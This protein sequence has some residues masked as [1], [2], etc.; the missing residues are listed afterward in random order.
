MNKI[1]YQS[2]VENKD[3]IKCDLKFQLA[4]ILINTSYPIPDYIREEIRNMYEKA[5]EYERETGDFLFDVVFR[6]DSILGEFIEEHDS[7]FHNKDFDITYDRVAGACKRIISTDNIRLMNR[8][9]P[10]FMA[11]SQQEFKE[12]LNECED[13]MLEV[14]R[15]S[16]NFSDSINIIDGKKIEYIVFEDNCYQKIVFRDNHPQKVIK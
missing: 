16:D 15:Q 1:E 10:L 3:Y 7:I 12:L 4:S 9:L 2:V 6:R 14:I 13:D 5:F 8:L 11:D